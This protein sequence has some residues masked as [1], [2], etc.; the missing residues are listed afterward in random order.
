MDRGLHAGIAG[1]HVHL[2]L[3]THK[4]FMGDGMLAGPAPHNQD[5]VHATKISQGYQ[6]LDEKNAYRHEG[7]SVFC[8]YR[9][10]TA[11]IPW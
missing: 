9:K 3:A 8:E 6:P 11:I 1:R 7:Y 2:Q 10:V 4:G 5:F